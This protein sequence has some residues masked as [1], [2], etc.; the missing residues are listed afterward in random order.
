MVSRKI[1]MGVAACHEGDA[2]GKKF[3]EYVDYLTST[4]LTFPKARNAI[5]AIRDIGNEANHTLDFLNQDQASAPS[6]SSS[7]C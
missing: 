4:V 1:L 6:R 5:N 2:D 3:V 7:I